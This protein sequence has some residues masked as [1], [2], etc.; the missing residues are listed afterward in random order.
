MEAFLDFLYYDFLTI[1]F[2]IKIAIAVVFAVLTAAGPGMWDRFLGLNLLGI[3]IVMVMIVFS[4]MEGI[5]FLLDMAI[6]LTLFDFMGTIFIALFFVRLR[7]KDKDMFKGATM[8][9]KKYF[10]KPRN[11]DEGGVV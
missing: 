9:I 6:L 5:T 1:I 2:W 7:N 4:S 3:K 10:P 11:N 8:T